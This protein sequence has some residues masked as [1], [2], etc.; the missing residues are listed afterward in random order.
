M[1][2][3]LGT[4]QFGMPYGISN[5]NGQVS[6]ADARAILSLAVAHGIDV[7]DTA[8]AYGDSE[9]VIRQAAPDVNA[10]RIVTK[11]PSLQ[12]RGITSDL[13]YVLRQDLLQSLDRLGCYSPYGYLLHDSRDLLAPTGH[14]LVET[15]WEVKQEGLVENVGVSIYTAAEIDAMLKVFTPDIVQVPVS[16][17][18]Q[19]LLASGHLAELK[20]RGVEIHARSIFLQGLLLMRPEELPDFC[21]PVADHVTQFMRFVQESGTT[22]LDAALAFIAQV[23]EIDVAIVGVSSLPDLE[24]ILRAVERNASNDVRI[25]NASQWAIRDERIVNPAQWPK[26]STE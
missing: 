7:L 19:R 4:A 2:L 3:G 26:R 12:T 21:A 8:A 20:R 10:F 23:P 11:A 6:V 24:G 18:D 16:L 9:A 14:E 22:S 5:R 15:L 17:F 1:K 13:P 25:A